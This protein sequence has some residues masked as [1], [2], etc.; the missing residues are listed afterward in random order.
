MNWE[1]K[2]IIQAFNSW[3]RHFY[4]QFSIMMFI[5]SVQSGILLKNAHHKEE[6]MAENNIT[7]KALAAGF[8]QLLQGKS[9][10]SISVLDI[11]K[12]CDL[13]RQSFYYHFHDKYELVNWIYYHEALAVIADNLSYENWSAKVLQLLE[14]MRNDGNFYQKTLRSAKSGEFQDYLFEFFKD[15]FTRIIATIA[16][17]ENREVEEK[18]YVAE[19]LAYGIVGMV[20]A[21]AKNGM[22]QKP[23]E[24]VAHIQ[25]ALNDGKMYAISRY[26]DDNQR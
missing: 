25:E 10:E 6:T 23:E 18:S 12:T 19:F 22:K 24:I 15:V 4:R 11:A 16:G 3:F 13:N 14:I 8:K 5:V 7:K 9:F 21:W 2:W 17:L 20:V 26:Q 1:W